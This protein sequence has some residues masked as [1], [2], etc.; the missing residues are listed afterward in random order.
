M[1]DGDDRGSHVPGEP[2]EGAEGH[3]G[4]HPEQVQMVASRLLQRQWEG[5]SCL[6]SLLPTT[7]WGGVG[8]TELPQSSHFAEEIL[9]AL[10]SLL[11]SSLQGLPP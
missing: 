4:A 7:C 5:G 6:G 3:E 1:G 8:E 2:H 11:D 10:L 9:R